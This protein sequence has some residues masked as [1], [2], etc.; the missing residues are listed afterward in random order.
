MFDFAGFQTGVLAFLL[1]FL[2]AGLF[3]VA[4]PGA[5]H[6]DTDF[7]GADRVVATLDDI[8]PLLA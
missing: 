8:V 1:A 5:W 3:T 2:V 6:G 7:S 4:F